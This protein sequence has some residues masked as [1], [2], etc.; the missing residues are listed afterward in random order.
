LQRGGPDKYA[1]VDN[2]KT[3][4]GARTRE[5]DPKTHNVYLVTAKLVPSKAYPK[6]APGTVRLLIFAK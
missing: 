2:V 5:V 3:A 1:V 4:E 6:P